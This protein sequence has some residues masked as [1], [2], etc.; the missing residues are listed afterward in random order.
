MALC[1]SVTVARSQTYW[2]TT[3]NTSMG[4]VTNFIG[5][6]DNRPM[7]ARTD[8]AWRLGLNQTQ[9]YVVN[10]SFGAKT[11]NGWMLLSPDIA[12]F[13]SGAN[14]P[15]SLLHLAA[16]TNN[17]Q[18]SSDRPWMNVGVTLTGNSDHSYVG[19]KANASDKTDM[20]IHWVR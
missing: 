6:T 15:Y 14:G 2:E 11:A 13:L 9:N 1:L 8:N 18:T 5:N 19:Q 17:A 4:P 16:A 10:S 3:G 12:N 20:V 7:N